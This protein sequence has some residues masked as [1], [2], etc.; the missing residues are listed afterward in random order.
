M[1]GRGLHVLQ[2]QI[3]GVDR[4]E[5][6]AA[7]AA[8]QAVR[9]VREH[10]EFH[11]PVHR[12]L[13]HGPVAGGFGRPVDRQR[14]RHLG[15]P[16]QVLLHGGAR[17]GV[18]RA[19]HLLQLSRLEGGDKR[20]WRHRR[21]TRPMARQQH[22]R[23][24][25]PDHDDQAA[26]HDEPPPP[27]ARRGPQGTAARTSR[28]ARL[29]RRRIRVAVRLW[30]VKLSPWRHR[31]VLRRIGDLTRASGLR[32]GG[33]LRAHPAMDPGTAEA[34]ARTRR[35]GPSATGAPGSAGTARA[36]AAGRTAGT[37]RVGSARGTPRP[38]WTDRWQVSPRRWVL[39]VMVRTVGP[40]RR[41]RRRELLLGHARLRDRGTVRNGAIGETGIGTAE[42]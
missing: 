25:R 19:W 18:A 2:R 15:L 40:G 4:G 13:V 23:E 1:L 8:G 41:A 26:C 16:R 33:M 34:T 14:G 11:Q 20:A 7:V 12:R 35:M 36:P 38:R 5:R 22:H 10:V 39:V 24:H 37:G 28:P 17:H 27:P 32:T 31:F 9:R 42:L 6:G 3:V 21:R 30:F 29:N